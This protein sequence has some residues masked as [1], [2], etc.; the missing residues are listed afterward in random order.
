MPDVMIVLLNDNI[1]HLCWWPQMIL[2]C[3]FYHLETPALA[4]AEIERMYR[5][6]LGAHEIVL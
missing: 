6:Y 2:K 3:F 5:T 4:A 1:F